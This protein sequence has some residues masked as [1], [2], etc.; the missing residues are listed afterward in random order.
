MTIL[1][2]MD[3]T[4]EHLLPAWLDFLNAKY[5]RNVTTDDINNWDLTLFYPGIPA[6]EVYDVVNHDDFWKNVKPMEGAAEVLERFIAKGHD[7][8]IVT[9]TVYQSIRGKM[10]Y[11]LFKYFP[12]LTWQNVIITSRKQLLKADIMIDDGIHNLEGGDYHKI[13]VTA[14]YNR[15]YDA[16][17]N[18]MV[19]CNNW[20]EIEEAVNEFERSCS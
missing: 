4:I 15:K 10:D 12:F 14:P 7:V 9:A 1:V 13:L 17:A 20:K 19:R 5:G 11:L 3:E 16:K 8:Y 18:N 6:E 2:D